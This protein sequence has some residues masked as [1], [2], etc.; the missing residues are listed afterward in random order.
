[1]TPQFFVE[2]SWSQHCTV[3]APSLTDDNTFMR[4]FLTGRLTQSQS[5]SPIAHMELATKHR[6]RV[7]DKIHRN[8]CEILSNCSCGSERPRGCP[9]QKA[10]HTRY[11]NVPGFPDWSIA[12]GSLCHMS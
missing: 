9:I 6:S 10:R 2:T 7:A 1:M 3:Q 11:S 8:V 5:P 12:R 4:N